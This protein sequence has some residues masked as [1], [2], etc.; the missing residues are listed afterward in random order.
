MAISGTDIFRRL[1]QRYEAKIDVARSRHLI[2]LSADY[3]TCTELSKLVV[4]LLENIRHDEL[5][6]TPLR[7]SS[8]DSQYKTAFNQV[9][10][11]KVLFERIEK[12]TSTVI[13]EDGEEGFGTTKRRKKDSAIESIKVDSLRPVQTTRLMLVPGAY[14]LSWTGDGRCR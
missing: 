3:A 2:R 12:I 10:S 14:L 6:L 8:P 4:F 7:S 1:S 11:D 13:Q 9:Q 5:D